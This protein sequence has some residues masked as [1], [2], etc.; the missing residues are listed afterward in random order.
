MI[1]YVT[2]SNVAYPVYITVPGNI[3]ILEDVVDKGGMR[4]QPAGS[5]YNYVFNL[6]NVGADSSGNALSNA[7]I[8]AESGTSAT[9][10]RLWV[11]PALTGGVERH[12]DNLIIAVDTYDAGGGISGTRFRIAPNQIK[13]NILVEGIAIYSCPTAKMLEFGLAYRHNS[14]STWSS[15]YNGSSQK[16]GTYTPGGVT[17]NVYATTHRIRLAGRTTSDI[18]WVSPFIRTHDYNTLNGVT[19]ESLY[20]GVGVAG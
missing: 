15:A 20:I 9:N 11:K 14:D 2:S 1:Q 17:R 4:Y 3:R 5:T 19:W 6:S 10:K 7:A 16:L 12:K 13:Y 18:W 8:T